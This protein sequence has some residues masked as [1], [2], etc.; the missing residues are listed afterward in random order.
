MCISSCAAAFCR[1]YSI[2]CN[3][4]QVLCYR[5]T[6]DKPRT[7]FAQDLRV[8]YAGAIGTSSTPTMQC[9]F[10]ILQLPESWSRHSIPQPILMHW[11]LVFHG[12]VPFKSLCCCSSFK[13]SFF[14][15]GICQIRPQ[16]LQMSGLLLL[17]YSCQPLSALI[18]QL[19]GGCSTLNRSLITL[20]MVPATG[21]ST[22]AFSPKHPSLAS[23]MESFITLRSAKCS[24]GRR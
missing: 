11:P 16:S 9:I 19:L 7:H 22:C 5:L 8:D 6:W 1:L 10:L 18:G 20:I 23:Q 15:P 3:A 2:W 12:N 17:W 21:M 14:Q 13:D 24:M 4:T